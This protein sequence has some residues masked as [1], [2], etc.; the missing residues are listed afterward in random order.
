MQG[1]K[2]TCTFKRKKKEKS[3]GLSPW[4]S[5]CS[6][7]L[8]WVSPLQWIHCRQVHSRLIHSLEIFNGKPYSI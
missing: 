6:S 3:P 2:F 8:A 1:I 4:A 7:D 5:S